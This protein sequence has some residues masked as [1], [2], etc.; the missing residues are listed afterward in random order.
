M[1]GGTMTFTADLNAGLLV[2]RDVPATVCDQCGAEWLDN[3]AS[4]K[5][6]E[7]A[8]EM[9]TKG[10]QVEIVSYRQ[11]VEAVSAG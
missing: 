2:V 5:I 1:E 10:A 11:A 4:A 8:K 9:Q 7:Y 3:D 6:D